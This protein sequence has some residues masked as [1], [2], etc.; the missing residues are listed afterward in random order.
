MTEKVKPNV[1]R[2][3]TITERQDDG[4]PPIVLIRFELAF[5]ND[6]TISYGEI[7]E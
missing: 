2:L 6:V 1:R 5:D 3:L 7:C 4:G